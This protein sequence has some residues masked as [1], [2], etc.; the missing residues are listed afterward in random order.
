M[1]QSN[2]IIKSEQTHIIRW[3]K[4][5]EDLSNRIVKIIEA[6]EVDKILDTQSVFSHVLAKIS[7]QERSV[8]STKKQLNNRF[9]DIFI[10]VNLWFNIK[11]EDA[12]IPVF[13]DLPNEPHVLS[14]NS[15]RW[16]RGFSYIYGL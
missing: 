8:F 14:Y 13:P 6:N 5:S 12:F 16:I 4:K 2:Q 11:K 7:K 3:I 15:K 9:I 1:L 10:P